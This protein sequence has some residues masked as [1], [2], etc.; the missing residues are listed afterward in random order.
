[1]AKDETSIQ[2]TLDESLYNAW[3][4]AIRSDEI[5]FKLCFELIKKGADPYY[6]LDDDA[7]APLTNAIMHEQWSAAKKL[8]DIAPLRHTECEIVRGYSPLLRAC[9]SMCYSMT[10]SERDW[11]NPKVNVR[12]KEMVELLI[13]AGADLDVVCDHGWNAM[14]MFIGHGSLEMV[15]RLIKAGAK[16]DHEQ[17]EVNPLWVCLVNDID[18]ARVVRCI[19]GH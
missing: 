7:C 1:M 6:K 18:N 19:G 14:S 11:Q 10:T 13:T 12:A 17:A 4:G 2:E 8:L 16:L 3:R 9:Y 5:D 15:N